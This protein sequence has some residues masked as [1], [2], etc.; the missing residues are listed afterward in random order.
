MWCFR[1]DP[2]G[3]QIN[4]LL[5]QETPEVFCNVQGVSEIFEDVEIDAMEHFKKQYSTSTILNIHGIMQN[6]CGN[7][8]GHSF[9]TLGK[10]TP[11]LAR[12]DT[13]SIK[14]FNF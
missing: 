7:V 14:M 6:Y 4:Q 12:N 5:E 3:L 8:L 9:L 2:H 11:Y 1:T 13:Y 10:K